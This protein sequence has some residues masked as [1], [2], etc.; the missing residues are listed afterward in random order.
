MYY[1]QGGMT[2]SSTRES[3]KGLVVEEK[4][5]VA[6]CLAPEFSRF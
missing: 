3:L 6:E 2:R 5:E 4:D 1:S